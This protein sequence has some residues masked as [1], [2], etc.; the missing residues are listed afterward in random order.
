VSISIKEGTKR[1]RERE[2][3]REIDKRRDKERERERERE[4]EMIIGNNILI[5][6]C[7]LRSM[8][9]IIHERR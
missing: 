8:G 6:N 5:M 4:R 1:E 9:R 2:R 3:E 7:C